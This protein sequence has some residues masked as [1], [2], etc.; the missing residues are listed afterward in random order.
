VFTPPDI[1]RA[2]NEE[3][4]MAAMD[5]KKSKKAKT[6]PQ[7]PI[8]FVANLRDQFAMAAPGWFT[9][10][11]GHVEAATKAAYLWADAMLKARDVKP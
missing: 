10:G 3:A 11:R 1:L 4:A 9:E 7:K 5:E 6:E 8:P 2:M